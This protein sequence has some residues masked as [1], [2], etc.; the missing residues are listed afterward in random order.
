LRPLTGFS[1]LAHR[2]QRERRTDKFKPQLGSPDAGLN[3]RQMTVR[4]QLPEP[5]RNRP[6][7]VGIAIIGGMSNSRLR[8]RDLEVPF[9]GVRS[10]TGFATDLPGRALAYFSRA[11]E[12]AILSHATAARIWGIPL[13]SRWQEDERI[14]VSLPPDMRAPRGKGVAGHHLR[15]HPTDV[16]LRD[17]IRL[18]SQERT[19]CD[20]ATIL[21]EEDLLAA[22][23]YLLWWRRGDE[24]RSTRADI[25]RAINRHPTSRG[26]AKLRGVA[27]S[28][29][30]RSDSPP[31]S[32]VRLRILRAGLPAPRVNIELYDSRGRFLAMPDLCYPEYKLALDY[33]GDHHR[34]DLVQWE[35]DIHRVPRLQDEGWSHTRLSRGDLR[36]STD[37]LTRLRRNLR[38]KGWQAS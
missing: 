8:G 12:L 1:L 2:R 13:P 37:F 7:A 35:K 5:L 32:I 21:E 29:S 6:F 34:T 26:M 27:R 25:E 33:E 11:S 23:D 19:L 3:A 24:H 17:G 15:L 16:V 18:T 36:N 28:A 30:D 31:E 14:H 22:V 4:R 10:P 9:W 20:L 38:S